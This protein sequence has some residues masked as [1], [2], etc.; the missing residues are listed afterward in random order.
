MENGRP[1]GLG[2]LYYDDGELRYVGGIDY[3]N[4]AAGY[5]RYYRGNGNV[6]DGVFKDSLL[7]DGKR[8]KKNADGTH[9]CYEFKDK[10]EGKCIQKAVKLYWWVT[11]SPKI[12]QKLKTC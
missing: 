4:S 1:S 8:Y 5:G 10:K 2:R 6:E 3:N 11:Q 12:D 9:D 7:V